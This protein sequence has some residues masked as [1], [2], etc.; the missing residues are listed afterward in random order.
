[1]RRFTLPLVIAGCIALAA[2]LTWIALSSANFGTRP[3]RA[4]I[5][6]GRDAPVT[7][8][9][10]PFRRIDVSGAAEV[11]LVQGAGES[12]ALSAASRRSSYLSAKVKGD[13]L[14]I[15]SD[16]HSRWWDFL[17]SGNSARGSQVVVTYKDLDTITAAGT[18]K[19]TAAG[20]KVDDLRITGAGGTTIRID[21]L[22]A[23]QLKLSGAGALRADLSG[24]VGEQSVTISGAGDFRG[25]K[26]VSQDATVTVAGAGRV[27]INAEKT[28]KAT[29]SGAGSV[30]Y[31]GDPVVTERVSGAGRVKRRDAAYVMAPVA[32]SIPLQ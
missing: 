18:V 11:M 9:V 5:S 19:L 29:I 28:L 31:V 2:L 20:M 32:V 6:G 12:V 17:L 1:M 25:A 8:A 16:D 30:E 7:Q 21:D 22:S 14:Y 23:R 27:V 13:T 3:P 26:L 24:R 10:P 15:E 4:E